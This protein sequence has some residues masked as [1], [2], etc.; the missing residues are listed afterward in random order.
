MTIAIKLLIALLVAAAATGA[1]LLFDNV[2]TTAGLFALVACATVIT[3]MLTQLPGRGATIGRD[4]GAGGAPASTAAAL[5]RAAPGHGREQGAVK[6]FSQKKGF[7]FIIRDNG[8]EIFV[9]YRN[10]QG[11]GRR[12][13]RDGERV[14]FRVSETDKGPQAEE[15]ETVD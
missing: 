11:D 7:G 4:A 10:I 2:L 15:V 3:A 13:L 6:W 8:D 5:R 1:T 14:T 12:T 9:H